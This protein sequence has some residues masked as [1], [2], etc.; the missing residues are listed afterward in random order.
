MGDMDKGNIIATIDREMRQR[1]SRRMDGSNWNWPVIDS[2]PRNT[3]N[4]WDPVG[5][6]SSL[7]WNLLKDL[8][9]E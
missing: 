1:S 9:V 2:S 8:N 4:L 7:F 5:N 6:G 3:V